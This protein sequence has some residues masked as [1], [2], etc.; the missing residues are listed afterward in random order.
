MAREK[1]FDTV[2]FQSEEFYAARIYLRAI[3]Y[4]I[5]DY[6]KVGTF[7]FINSLRVN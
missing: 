5:A 4:T 1:F 7:F 3:V 2:D 6:F